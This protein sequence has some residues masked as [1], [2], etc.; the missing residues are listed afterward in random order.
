M[1]YDL[2]GKIYGFRFKIFPTKPIHWFP[3]QFLFAEPVSVRGAKAVVSNT[4][5][6]FAR[7]ERPED[8]DAWGVKACRVTTRRLGTKKNDRN[9]ISI[10]VI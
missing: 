5:A 6:V 4:R 3:L 9:A 8:D 10:M 2:N 1:I 7:P